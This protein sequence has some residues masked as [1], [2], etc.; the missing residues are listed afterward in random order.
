MPIQGVTLLRLDDSNH[1]LHTIARCYWKWYG[2]V[3]QLWR[4]QVGAPSFTSQIRVW[5]ALDSMAETGDELMV[6]LAHSAKPS[7]LMLGSPAAELEGGCAAGFSG[8]LYSPASLA[9]QRCFVRP[10]GPLVLSVLLSLCKRPRSRR[11]WS[12]HRPHL[13][14]AS[15]RLLSLGQGVC[16]TQSHEPIQAEGRG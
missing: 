13:V 4:G 2:D 5:P 6:T 9:W 1:W 11:Y 16:L 3:L 12:T 14:S 7:P 8:L 15:A 10:F